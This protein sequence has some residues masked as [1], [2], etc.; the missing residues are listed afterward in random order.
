MTEHDG[1]SGGVPRAGA[2]KEWE[3]R[4]K[5]KLGTSSGKKKGD[6]RGDAASKGGLHQEVIFPQ[7]KMKVKWQKVPRSKEQTEL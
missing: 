6:E 2:V 5:K 4:G 7:R 3:K 1:K